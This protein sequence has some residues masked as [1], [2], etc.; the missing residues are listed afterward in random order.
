MILID[1]P[2]WPNHGTV[3]AHLVSDTSYA[4][5]HDFAEA[6]GLPK[7]AFDGDHYDVPLHY[8]DAVRAAGATTVPAGELVRRLNERGLRLRK[9][10]GERGVARVLDADLGAG[11]CGDVDLVLS[12][13]LAPPE[14]TGAAAVVLSDAVGDVLM[15]HSI[16]RGTWDSPGGRVERGESASDCAVR[17]L[18]EELGVSLAADALQPCGYERVTTRPDPL[19]RPYIQVFT[20]AL[21]ETRPALHLAPDELSGAEWL[22]GVALRDRCAHRF[23]WPLVERVLDAR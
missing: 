11:M 12:A 21:A 2:I 17:E 16:R 3:F 18:A 15:V 23:W 9:R 20:A 22:T 10:R 5:L 13:R 14:T 1:R 19:R 4:E 6:A 8:V 7:R